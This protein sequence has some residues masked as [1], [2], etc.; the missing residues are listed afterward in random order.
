MIFIYS[1]SH[2]EHEVCSEKWAGLMIHE[3]G[4]MKEKISLKNGEKMSIDMIVGRIEELEKLADQSSQ[5][6]KDKIGKLRDQL[7][8]IAEQLND[9]FITGDS[10]LGEK[11]SVEKASL[12]SRINYLENFE[13]RRKIKQTISDKERDEL[14]KELDNEMMKIAVSDK[15][16]IVEL[17]EEMNEIVCRADAMM[18]KFEYCKSHINIL[19]KQRY[20]S[21]PEKEI[22]YFYSGIRKFANN[23]KERSYSFDIDEE[24]K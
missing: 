3:P 13:S 1:F 18:K 6:A 19:A 24:K 16:R 20:D 5:E 4:I 9:T 15:K 17:A 10:K 7:K 11:L 22:M 23:Y 2:C 14:R 21:L 8:S 12:E